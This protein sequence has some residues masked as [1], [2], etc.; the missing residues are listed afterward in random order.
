[1]DQFD[2]DVM[3]DLFYETAEGPARSAFEEEGFEE[4]F[5]EEGFEEA[6]DEFLSRI[7]GGIGQAVGGLLGADEFEEGEGFD[8]FSEGEYGEEFEGADS[9]EDAVADA[10]EAEDTDEFLRRLR[11]IARGAVNVA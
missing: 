10:M 1:M 9:F 4:G 2:T 6:D 5:E 7:V 11:R 8:E 3:D